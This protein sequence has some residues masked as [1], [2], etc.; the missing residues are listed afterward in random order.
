MTVCT[1]RKEEDLFDDLT[2]INVLNK[3]EPETKT[4]KRFMGT[5]LLRRAHYFSEALHQSSSVAGRGRVK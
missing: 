1:Y 2:R 3:S 5:F 4:F